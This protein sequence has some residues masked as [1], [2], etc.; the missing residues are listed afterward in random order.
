MLRPWAARRYQFSVGS[1]EKRVEIRP[2]R[3]PPIFSFRPGLT[4]HAAGLL[5]Y[6]GAWRAAAQ[7]SDRAAPSAGGI[8]LPSGMGLTRYLCLLVKVELDLSLAHTFVKALKGTGCLRTA[9]VRGPCGVT[10][11]LAAT[12]SGFDLGLVDVRRRAVIAVSRG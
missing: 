11:L 1:G 6:A 4:Q 5:L 10:T 7:I 8:R 9:G 2:R 12:Y 3:Q